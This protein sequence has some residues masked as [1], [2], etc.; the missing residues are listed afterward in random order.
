MSH[1]TA[2]SLTL[3]NLEIIVKKGNWDK[4]TSSSSLGTFTTN[5]F[6]LLYYVQCKTDATKLV[7]VKNDMAGV[8]MSFISCD[9]FSDYL[10]VSDPLVSVFAFYLKPNSKLF[11]AAMLTLSC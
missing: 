1:G 6:F 7:L 2:P 9:Y 10:Q 11:I 8:F 4:E 5:L 3:N